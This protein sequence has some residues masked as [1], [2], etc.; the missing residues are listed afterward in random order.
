MMVAECFGEILEGKFPQD[1]THST[2]AG[3]H[4][5]TKLP[6]LSSAKL[7]SISNSFLAFAAAAL[8]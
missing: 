8:R 4:F 6:A 7:I 3:L 5:K 1:F 2:G